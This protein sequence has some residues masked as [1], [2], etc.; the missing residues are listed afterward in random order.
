MKKH[1]VRAALAG[2]LLTLT[3][4]GLAACSTDDAATVQPAD[5]VFDGSHVDYATFAAATQVSGVTVIDVRT[6]SEYAAGHIPG[7]INVDVSAATF[8][9]QIAGLDPSADYAVYCQ[10]GNRSRAAVATMTAAG[11]TALIGLE[12]GI[13]AWKGDVVTG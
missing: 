4:P 2:A 12:G 1:L 13:G 5:V 10:S 3:V 6:P 11:F 9:T 7:A 8:P